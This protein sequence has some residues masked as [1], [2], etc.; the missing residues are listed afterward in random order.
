[1]KWIDRQEPLDSALQQVASQPVIAV[2][3]EADS[4]HSY[5]DKVC[6]IQI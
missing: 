5:F 2:D 4:L 3:T 1:M 6:L